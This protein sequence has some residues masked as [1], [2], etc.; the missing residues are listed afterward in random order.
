MAFRDYRGANSDSCK[1]KR[2]LAG[3]R[4]IKVINANQIVGLGR[5]ENLKTL[6]GEFYQFYSDGI[7]LDVSTLVDKRIMEKVFIGKLVFI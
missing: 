2:H 7:L 5:T 1:F 4:G 6:V 3:Y